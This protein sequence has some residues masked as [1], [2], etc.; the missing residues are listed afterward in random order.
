MT[1]GFWPVKL[2]S[3]SVDPVTDTLW[4]LIHGGVMAILVLPLIVGSQF[5]FPFIVLK[6]VLFRVLVEILLV[7][8]AFLAVRDRNFRPTFNALTVAV[9]G[10]FGVVTLTTLTGVDLAG[11]VWG[12][13][14]RMG[15][16]FGWLHVAAFFF[17]LV[18][19]FRR[20]EDWC[21]LMSFSIFVSL[22]MGLFAFGQWLHVPFLIRSSGGARLTATIG[23]ATYLAGYLLFHLFFLGYF[24]VRPR[25]FNVKLLLWSVVG[26]DL[27]L[28][29][30]DA[31][32]RFDPAAASSLLPQLFSS[33]PLVLA[34]LL[35]NGAAGV[36]YFV[37]GNVVALRAILCSFGAF[38]FFVFY[39]TQTRGAL[40]GLLAALLFV[41]LTV[42]FMKRNTAA[43][44]TGLVL[45]VLGL[46][47]PVLLYLARDSAFVKND[48][49]LTRLAGISLHDVTSQSRLETWKASWLGWA[50]DPV[51]FLIGYGLEN[52]AVVYNRHFPTAVYKDQGSQIWFDRAHNIVFETGVTSGLVGLVSYLGIFATAAFVLWRYYQKTGRIAEAVLPLATLLAYFVQ[53]LFVFDTLESY[54]LSSLVLA[55]IVCRAGTATAVR[56][57]PSPNRAQPILAPQT[58]LLVVLTSAAAFSLY[59]YNYQMLAANHK[60]YAA[61]LQFAQPDPVKQ[62]LLFHQAISGSQTG[63]LEARQQYASFALGLVRNEA[64][65]RGIVR[66]LLEDALQE[67][68]KSAEEQPKNIRNHLYF[69]SVANRANVVLPGSARQAIAV[70]EPAVPLSPARP[71]VYFELGQAYLIENDVPRALERYR[72]GLALS[73]HVLESHLDVAVAY[74][75]MER[76]EDALRQVATAQ[77]K[78]PGRITE[79]QYLRL[80]R[81]ADS[82]RQYAAAIRLY[83]DLFQVIPPKAE[84]YASLASVFAKSGDTAKAVQA[85]QRALELDPSIQDQFD[86][87]MKQIESR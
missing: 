79:E 68:K 58:V 10:F 55:A 69:A 67:L 63:R 65:S 62:R 83:E 80:T 19:T 86:A 71:Q 8:Y 30:Y 2:K 60:I 35:L 47:A 50:E 78:F 37:R 41:T 28:V 39:Q 25:E 23:N 61:L 53:N 15:G 5:F 87:F 45:F 33:S 14:E 16:L 21:T 7:A 64:V 73:E 18:N 24:L 9:L 31:I 59:A 27:A 56:P 4:W 26:F 57:H 3:R 6:N 12:N 82:A 44:K 29:G 51:R 76:S 13:Y 74:L 84:H 46:A 77:Q 17:V 75:L 81:A 34:M 49:T 54:V 52:Y 85:A 70:L 32:Y 66:E 1:D 48:L 22:L 11:S 20:W 38:I 72:Q 40:I 36:G 43:G 42:G